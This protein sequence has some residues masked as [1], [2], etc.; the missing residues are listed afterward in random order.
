M[1]KYNPLDYSR[2]NLNGDGSNIFKS[3]LPIE[4][5]I[6]DFALPFQDK[7]NDEG[8][9]EI[10]TY[11][12]LKLN[13]I[14]RGN[15]KITIPAAILHDVGWSQLSKTELKQ[16]YL[17][18]WKEFD[19]QLRKRHQEQGVK[20]A[21]KLLNEINYP[22]KHYKEILDIIS[23]HDTRKGFLS[24][25][26]GIVR[27][28]DKLWRFIVP[29]WK[30]AIRERSESPKTIYDAIKGYFSKKGFFYSNQAKEIAK[31]EFNQL[32]NFISP[33]TLQ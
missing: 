30:M 14:L 4:R 10:V 18:N 16:F 24:L 20:L 33:K 22:K 2:F 15:R 8:H 31:I 1:Q 27:D 12:A 17:P 11:F 25:N 21:G 13:D 28:A 29:H 32:E 3:L 26:D 6:W 7:R 19:S 9:A 23:E 5:K